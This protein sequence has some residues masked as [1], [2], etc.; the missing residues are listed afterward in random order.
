M[1]D[2]HDAQENKQ[3]TTTVAEEIKLESIWFSV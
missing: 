1:I 3:K 2:F